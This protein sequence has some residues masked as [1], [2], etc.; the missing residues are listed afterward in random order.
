MRKKKLNQRTLLEAKQMS[1]QSCPCQGSDLPCL[2][3]DKTKTYR[4][5]IMGGTFDPIHNGHLVAAE[6]ACDELGLDL[7]LF[8]PAGNPAFKQDREVSSPED[9]FAMTLLATADNPRFITSRAEIEREGI[10]YTADT[11]QMLRA[12][13]PKNVELFFITGADALLDIAKWKDSK[14]IAEMV[15]F[16]GATR[17]GYDLEK[18]H[19]ELEKSSIPFDVL[20]LEVPAL[21]ISSS[22]LRI[23]QEEGK[24][25][26]YLTCDSVIG[27]INKHHLYHSRKDMS[28]PSAF[29]VVLN[30]PT[31]F[32]LKQEKKI[33]RIEKDV[34]KQLKKKP[35]RLV[36]SLEV[37]RIAQALARQYGADTQGQYNAR[38]AGVLHDWEKAKSAEEIYKKAQKIGLEHDPRLAGIKLK[39]AKPLLHGFVGAHTLAKL[40]PDLTEDM[41]NAIALH[42][43]GAKKMDFL[44][45][46]IY[47]ADTIDPTRGSLPRLVLLRSL[48]GKV[49]LDELYFC[50]YRENIDYVIATNRYLLPEALDIFNVLV[51]KRKKAEN[52]GKN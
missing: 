16:V 23:R 18:V 47:I 11:L 49:S 14:K 38:V 46:I 34:A 5:G 2:G 41:L 17:P 4:L 25:L 36:H 3:E 30:Q 24:S 6:Q 22:E 8:M 39:D 28:F 21:A 51:E 32:S 31:V 50:C 1:Q 42:T 35:E 12:F 19:A 48:V 13:Y 52:L 43:L 20:Y 26:R 10:T 45:K 9:R 40:Y 29:Q 44:E 37:G 7:V 27:Y 15:T 33:E